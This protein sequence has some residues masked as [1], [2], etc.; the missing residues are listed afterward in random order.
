VAA[1][2]T[3]EPI[4]VS[5]PE[6]GPS[7]G[8]LAT[9]ASHDA[10][11]WAELDPIRYQLVTDIFDLAGRARA[12]AEPRQRIAA[13]GPDGW[14]AAWDRAVAAAAES[15]VRGIDSRLRAAAIEARLARRRRRA[16]AVAPA[17]A[18]AIL[19]RLG[20]GAGP[21]LAALDALRQEGAAA[22]GAA[23]E[24]WEHALTTAARRLEAAWI[25]LEEGIK[26]EQAGWSSEIER[27][28]SWRRP[29]WPVLVV[30][31]L[32][33]GAA[34]YLG[35]VIGGFLAAPDWLRPLVTWWWEIF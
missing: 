30:G 26:R 25:S 16:V 21:L 29:W 10:S 32:L 17:E 20:A 23:T 34:I 6:L 7:L 15:L 1:A 9:H 18:R 31:S 11:C 4:A 28:R 8:R 22:D 35:L 3:V 5:V 19:V 24:G 14:S 13:L 12:A 2:V 33:F 27:I